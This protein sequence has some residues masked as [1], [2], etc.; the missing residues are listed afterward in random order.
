[1]ANSPTANPMIHG[2]RALAFLADLHHT[3]DAPRLHWW[4]DSFWVWEESGPWRP[5][6]EK[7]MERKALRWL[8]AKGLSSTTDAAKALTA[9][10]S[11]LREL[12][13]PRTAQPPFWSPMRGTG[14]DR[15]LTRN[16]LVDPA[17]ATGTD[18]EGEPLGVEP[19]T[20]A[21]FTMNRLPVVYDPGAVCPLWEAFLADVLVAP[22]KVSALQEFMGILLTNETQWETA[23]FLVGAASSGKSTIGKVI[24]RVWG[25]D[26]VGHLP[27]ED[28]GARF[29]L[30]GLQHKLVNVC[31]E[32]CKEITPR[33]E[34]KLKWYISGG[35][36]DVDRKFLSRAKML[37]TA[38][39]VVPTNHW[40]EFTDSSDGTW[41]RIL[42]LRLTKSVPRE[43]RDR[44]LLDKLVAES[45]GIFNWALAGLRRARNRG[46]LIIPASGEADIA[47]RKIDHQGVSLFATE[48]LEDDPEGFLDNNTLKAEYVSWATR[49]SL[50]WGVDRNELRDAILMAHPSA[51]YTRQRTGSTRPWGVAGIR[52]TPK[53]NLNGSKA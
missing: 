39:L 25:D 7:E 53:E 51:T 5:C 32:T 37:P 47:S 33:L 2:Q 31:D 29:S 28:F 36:I 19:I 26:N 34:S 52:L 6:S 40:P 43:Q 1:M 18:F 4:G 15:I 48:A 50:P 16:Y 27:L 8:V 20:S 14:T 3:E 11:A 10:L 9:N 49:S 21:W 38:R 42:P 46:H 17:R 22:D 23:L 35:K 41:R 12:D 13:A 30:D 44:H 24:G 45:S